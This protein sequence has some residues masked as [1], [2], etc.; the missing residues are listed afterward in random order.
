MVDSTETKKKLKEAF[1]E[2]SEEER[3]ILDV[4]EKD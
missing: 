3:K 4:E 1:L 2:I